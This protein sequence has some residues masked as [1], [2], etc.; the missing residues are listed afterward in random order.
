MK[1]LIRADANLKIGTGHIMR[2]A[3]LG[4]KLMV[5][6]ASVR[7]LSSSLPAALAKWVRDCGF[8]LTT[9]PNESTSNWHA[10]FDT[11]SKVVREIGGIDLLIV[12]HYLLDQKWESKMRPYT[13]RILV[14]DDLANRDH[15]CDFLL[16][17]NLHENPQA[18]YLKLLP[19]SAM[20]FL[21]P[22]FAC[23]RNEFDGEG[24][25]FIRDGKV[26]R[27]L[28][29]FG[30]TDPG[31]QTLKVI[32]ALR[33]L[34]TEAPESTIVLGPA[35]PFGAMIHACTNGLRN[36]IVLDAT[37]EMSKLIQQADMGIGTCGVAA[38]ERCIFGLPSL[39]AITAEN[40]REDAEIL[41]R[42]GAVE[43]LGDAELL[44]SIHWKI[45]ISRA[46]NDPERIRRMS[47]ASKD[48]MVGRSEAFSKFLRILLD[49]A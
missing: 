14:I 16:D 33:S 19:K 18:R 26:K 3:A 42:L 30:G 45:A 35:N 39:V 43:N 15:D 13:K 31:N 49:V 48:V 4:A 41:D 32:E 21:G 11:T 29:F 34:G 27:L 40:Q 12:D 28:V 36:I 46:I 1:V 9:L 38:W 22:Q 2:C 37:D 20:L 23:L 6:G 47:V 7:F 10:D 17:Q 25:N 24:P 44:N 5:S 8:E